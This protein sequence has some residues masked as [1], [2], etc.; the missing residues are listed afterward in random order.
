MKKF[1]IVALG[2]LLVDFTQNGMSEQTNPL[3]EAN[4]GGAPCNV[5][6]MATRLGSKTA[7]IGKVGKDNFGKMLKQTIC[8]IKI[9]T[10]GLVIDDK[11]HTTLAFVSVDENGDR[12]FSFCRNPGADMMLSSDELN[13][14]ILENAKIFHFGTLSMTSEIVKN[15]TK[16]AIEISK[17]NGSLLSFDPN[18]RKPLWDSLN[19]AKESIW[20]G[21]SVCDIL[22]IS[23]D[24]LLFITDEKDIEKAVKIIRDKYPKIKIIF[25]TLGKDGSMFFYKEHKDYCPTFTDVKTIDTTGAGDTFCGCMLHYLSQND[26]D[27]LNIED[28]HQMLRFANGASS[29]ITTKKGSLKVMPSI[30]DIN[31]LIGN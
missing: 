15:A 29:L 23:E 28:L 17:K 2:E 26:I 25:V 12:D 31:K 19:D 20:Y 8:D 6:S 18:L 3:Y 10:S 30:D 5:L 11:I 9:D 16:K 7:F 13:T 22:K 4:P 24:E 1:D 14:D 21:I 27:N